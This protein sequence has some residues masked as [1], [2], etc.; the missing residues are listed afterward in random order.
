[1]S[2]LPNLPTRQSVETLLNHLTADADDIAHIRQYIESLHRRID[3]L[4]SVLADVNPDLDASHSQSINSPRTPP[5]NGKPLI[6]IVEDDI[7]INT[8]IKSIVE[9][10]GYAAL[11]AETG[12][13]GLDLASKYTPDLIICDI[14]L[15]GMHG[16]DVV[17]NFK[18]IPRLENI[19]IIMLTADLFKADASFELGADEYVMK[20][21]R[22][23]QLMGYITK[24]LA[25]V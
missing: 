20:P 25:T 12:Q 24:Y 8:M 13:D 2:H 3:Q 6:L 11:S 14:H 18:A 4:E 10:E 1:M 23:N 22:K 9:S 16:L 5:T 7:A 17:R 19:P 21:I 15:P